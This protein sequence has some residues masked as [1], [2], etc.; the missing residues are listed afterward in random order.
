MNVSVV[1]PTRNRQQWLGRALSS[2]ANQKCKSPLE[3]IVVDDG[4]PLQNKLVRDLAERYNAI[5]LSSGGKK[6]GGYARNIGVEHAKGEFIAFCDDDDE[7][8]EE[9]LAKQ[10]ILM[11]D[12]SIAMSYTGMFISKRNGRRRYSFRKPKFEDQY[13]SILQSN[14]IGTISTVVVRRSAFVEIGGFDARLP[15]LQDYDLYIR[16]L[17]RF[18]TGWIEEPLTIYYEDNTEGDKVSGSR[19]RFVIAR[20]LFSEKYGG[21]DQFGLLRKS[22]QW[23]VLL[24]CF[25]SRR[26]L[27]DTIRAILRRN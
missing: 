1:I 2:I 10:C 15:A 8:T 23:I 11:T 4:D 14:F 3:I 21:D 7:W 16:L 24:K 9:K 18:R 26:F 5:Y 27:K 17:R 20:R 13:R 12:S 22:L 25:R 19:E 6:G